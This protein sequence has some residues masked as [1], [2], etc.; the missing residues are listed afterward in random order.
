MVVYMPHKHAINPL[1]VLNDAARAQQRER[2]NLAKC[3][4][5]VELIDSEKLSCPWI[6]SLYSDVVKARRMVAFSALWRLADIHQWI[7][8][9]RFRPGHVIAE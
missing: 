2:R 4:V 9:V 6:G 8:N 5:T 1:C 7:A 3:I